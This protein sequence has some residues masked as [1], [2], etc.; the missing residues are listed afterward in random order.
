M[1]ESYKN[2]RERKTERNRK[3]DK[4][5]EKEK[6]NKSLREKAMRKTGN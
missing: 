3:K 6:G 5:F 1:K 2:E 4:E